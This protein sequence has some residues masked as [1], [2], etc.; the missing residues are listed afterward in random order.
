MSRNL[1]FGQL[2]TL[3]PLEL[4]NFRHDRFKGETSR[5]VLSDFDE[6][7]QASLLQVYRSLTEI[8]IALSENFGDARHAQAVLKRH[9]SH[10]ELIGDHATRLGHRT[11]TTSSLPHLRQV[12]HDIRGGALQ[13]FLMRWEMFKMMPEQ[14]TGL[15]GTFF[16]IRDHLKIMRNCVGD[17]DPEKFEIDSQRKDHGADL[18][19][20]K[21]GRADFYGGRVPARIEFHCAFQGTLCESCLEFST[22]DRI[23]YN[24]IS[25]AARHADDHMVGFYI[26][27]IP[28]EDHPENVRFVVVN[29]VSAVQRLTLNAALPDLG[30]L[31]LS[32]F[33]TD[34]HGIGARIVA[35]FCSQAYGILDDEVAGQRGYFGARWIAEDFVSWFHWP[36]AAP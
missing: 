21:W 12:V 35:D 9:A 31:F 18:L 3:A 32:G 2:M 6:N 22:L 36:T 30:N 15:L 13:G 20:E 10:Y 25:N 27:P 29:H 33:T 26:L 17:L 11:F 7:D 4:E 1:D 24:L 8:F 5:A 16:L 34:G 19:L 28:G 14:I 23:I